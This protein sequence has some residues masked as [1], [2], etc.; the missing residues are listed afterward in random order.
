MEEDSRLPGRRKVERTRNVGNIWKLERQDNQ[1]SLDR[2]EL[3]TMLTA[4]F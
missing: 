3:A 4:G 2:T 1:L